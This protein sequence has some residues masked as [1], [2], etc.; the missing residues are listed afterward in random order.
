MRTSLRP[1][2]TFR[3]T[4]VSASR[5]ITTPT[6]ISSAPSRVSCFLEIRRTIGSCW[7]SGLAYK[8]ARRMRSIL[9]NHSALAEGREHVSRPV[10]IRDFDVRRADALW[11]MRIRPHA[12]SNIETPR[13]F[14]GSKI[15]RWVSDFRIK[16]FDDVQ[17][18]CRDKRLQHRH[19]QS[20][21]FGIK[22][23]RCIHQAALG[24]DA[25]NHLGNRQYVRNPLR[26]EQADNFSGRRADLFANNNANS[27][28]ATEGLGRV[29]RMMV[30][31]A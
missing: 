6:C 16:Y 12:W 30:G 4:V 14:L 24:F 5:G 3:S 22:R 25:V 15:Q 20:G 11:V 13:E 9:S 7:R 21:P 31:D 18:T 27:E 28:V 10:E 29:D 1:P 23:M 17:L 26:Q 2:R 8:I 19:S